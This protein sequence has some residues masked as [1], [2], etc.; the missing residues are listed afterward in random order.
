MDAVLEMLPPALVRG[1]TTKTTGSNGATVIRTDRGALVAN[2]SSETI[3]QFLIDA[4]GYLRAFS[5]Y[6]EDLEVSAHQDRVRRRAAE[7]RL[8]EV[9]NELLAAANIGMNSKDGQRR[10]QAAISAV[11][12]H[13][14]PGNRHGYRGTDN[15]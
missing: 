14:R 10:V 8:T 4:P 1:S 6:I 7:E 3:A 2:C 12:E 15:R 5:A 11:R 9:S 13:G